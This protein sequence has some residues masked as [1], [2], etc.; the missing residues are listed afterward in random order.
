MRDYIKETV[1]IDKVI[2]VVSGGAP[3]ADSLAER[4]AK[5]EGKQLLIFHPQWSRYGRH[6]GMIRNTQI[7]D[8]ADVVFAFWNGFSK[9]TRDSIEKA[10]EK[11]KKL[12]V[13]KFKQ[14]D[15]RES[16]DFYKQ[17]S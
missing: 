14:S 16:K 11:N 9:G 4:F 10:K 17:E 3:G 5:E 12:Y 2:S 7:V 15:T 6:A 8:K 13:Y 1:N